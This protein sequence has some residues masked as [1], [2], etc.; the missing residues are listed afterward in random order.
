MERHCG[1][2]ERETDQ[3]HCK[4]GEH[5]SVIAA[6]VDLALKPGHHVGQR[7]RASTAIQ[8]SDAVEEKCRGETAENEVLHS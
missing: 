6:N 1:N 3:H 4:T 2:L 8:Q 7:G 5:K